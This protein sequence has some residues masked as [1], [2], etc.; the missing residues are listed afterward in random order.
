MSVLAFRRLLPSGVLIGL[1]MLWL[2][3]PSRAGAASL[4]ARAAI[5]YA[6]QTGQVLYADSAYRELPI[7]STTKLM[8]ALVALR[9]VHSLNTVF[10]DP[11]YYP[12]AADSQI[13]LVPGERMTVRDLLVALML[14]SA[15]DAAE[16][17]A[18][19]VGR[20][21]GASLSTAV[22]RFI[23]MMNAE[24]RQLGLRHTHYST[25][26]GLDTPGNFSSA[27]DLARL[28]GYDMSHSPF[29]ARIVD[30]PRAVLHSGSRVRQVLNRNDLVGRYGWVNGVKTGHT[31]DAGYVLVLS[32]H[33]N[34]M[35]LISVVLGTPSVT[36]R[37]AAA[38]GLLRYGFSH[39]RLREPVR[40]GQVLARPTVHDQPGQRVP[41]TAAATIERLLP[42]G[43]RIHLRLS[44]P[45][46]LSGPLPRQTVVGSVAVLVGNRVVG[47]APAL[48]SRTLPAVS[49]L[50]VAAR[51]ITQPVILLAICLLVGLALAVALIVRRRQRAGKGGLEPA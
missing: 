41:V 35:K 25:P 32:G 10:T 4:A 21:H 19:N 9:H 30:L 40:A 39:Y 5:V 34:G 24:A 29:F 44:V 50:T 22:D 17:L 8:T 1:A 14:P 16:D 6:P 43:S 49:A 47:H 15:D 48:L 2:L 20:T 38:F 45:A 18:Y 37:D 28:A 33:R 42:R 13:G 3:L 36:A 12:A 46:Q 7:A 31:A 27:F 23:A 11:D 51:F 26:I